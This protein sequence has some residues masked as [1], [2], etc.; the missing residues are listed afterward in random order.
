[1]SYAGAE[2]IAAQYPQYATQ[3]TAAAK[4]SFLDGADWAYLAG[5]IAVLI[6]ATLV[7]FAFPH[8]DEERRLL[9]SYHETDTRSPP[10]ADPPPAGSTPAPSP[11]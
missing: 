7:F 4:A 2:G 8:R 10:P 9:E 1:M 3:I 6:G 5:I 11:A